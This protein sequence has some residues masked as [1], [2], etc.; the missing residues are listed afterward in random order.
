MTIKEA[1]GEKNFRRLEKA[2]ISTQDKLEQLRP[3][4][5]MALAG[6]GPKTTAKLLRA[7][8]KPASQQSL[9]RTYNKMKQRT[10]FKNLPQRALGIV[11]DPREAIR[12]LEDLREISTDLQGLI[13]AVRNFGREDKIPTPQFSRSSLTISPL[14]ID[15]VTR[16]TLYSEII[17]NQQ[18]NR[19]EIIYTALDTSTGQIEGESRDYVDMNANAEQEIQAELSDAINKAPR[20][21]QLIIIIPRQLTSI[22]ENLQ[23]R[24]P[25]RVDKDVIIVPGLD[26]YYNYEVI[27]KYQDNKAYRRL[28]HDFEEHKDYIEYQAL[29]IK[30]AATMPFKEYRGS[31]KYWKVISDELTSQYEITYKGLKASFGPQPPLDKEYETINDPPYR[32][33][34]KNMEDFKAATKEPFINIG[35][36][37]IP[38]EIHTM[39]QETLNNQFIITYNDRELRYESQTLPGV[40]FK[41]TKNG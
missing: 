10:R 6:L 30:N 41:V 18:T 5:I 15:L 27:F 9:Q 19:Y 31:T 14:D 2:G 37:S 4:Q 23:T 28:V 17:V 20:G 35:P 40:G 29:L 32:Q 39:M 38:P 22:T 16:K 25:D 21:G 26:E 1:V 12:K 33:P 13:T 8:G 11:K 3:E 7:I 24:Y 34:Y 36:W